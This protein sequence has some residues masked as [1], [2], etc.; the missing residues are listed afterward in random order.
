MKKLNIALLTIVFAFLAMSA[1]AQI[2]G[3]WK[4]Q[5]NLGVQKLEVAFDIK[6]KSDL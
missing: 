5:L 1:H 2:E 4:G 6:V 3:Y